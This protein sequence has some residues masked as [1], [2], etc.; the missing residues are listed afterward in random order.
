MTAYYHRKTMILVIMLKN[1]N[2]LY[3]NVENAIT[4]I[5]TAKNA[6]LQFAP[7][8][9]EKDI[10]IQKCDNSKNNYG[11]IIVYSNKLKEDEIVGE[12]TIIPDDYRDI[13]HYFE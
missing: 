7:S 10:C 9:T 4:L 2:D 11:R 13:F 8:L 3:G 1:Y 6:I 5:N 12:Y